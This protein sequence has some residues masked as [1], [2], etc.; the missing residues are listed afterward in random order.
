MTEAATTARA[1]VVVSRVAKQ[2][3]WATHP[4]TVKGA[5]DDRIL[6]YCSASETSSGD[7]PAD[8]ENQ[9]SNGRPH[10]NTMM[11]TSPPRQAA[12]PKSSEDDFWSLE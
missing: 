9:P 1:G 2:M 4:M 6:L 7:C 12:T 3:D 8:P 11:D 10:P 5:T